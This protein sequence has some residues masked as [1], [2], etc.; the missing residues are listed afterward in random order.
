MKQT[1]RGG[2]AAAGNPAQPA[3]DSSV[4]AEGS[5]G[6]RGVGEG[7]RERGAKRIAVGA[8]AGAPGAAFAASAFA[9]AASSAVPAASMAAA[10]DAA[11]PAPAA[12]VVAA[13]SAKSIAIAGGRSSAAMR[14]EN[15]QR[16]RGSIRANASAARRALSC[17]TVAA[18]VGAATVANTSA[19]FAA[20]APETAP[21]SRRVERTADTNI[22]PSV[23]AKGTIPNDDTDDRARPPRVQRR[24]RR[25]RSEET[26][27]RGAGARSVAPPGVCRDA[28]GDVCTTYG[29]PASARAAA[30]R[31]PGWGWIPGEVRRGCPRVAR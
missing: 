13:T 11:P 26:S 30:P 24:P 2:G 9:N 17:A 25:V 23:D 1:V 21:P 19:I 29:A 4:A 20:S 15:R 31:R 16:R 22:P 6:R 10:N 12:G 14:R 5:R 18:N 3:A 7:S 28:P 27:V 8:R